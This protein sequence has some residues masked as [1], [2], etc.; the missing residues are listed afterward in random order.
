MIRNEGETTGTDKTAETTDKAADTSAPAT[1]EAGEAEAK[2]APAKRAKDSNKLPAGAVK[3]DMIY[4]DPEKILIPSDPEHYLFDERKDYPVN[5]RQV[6]FSKEFGCK[7]AVIG[8]LTDGKKGKEVLVVDGRQRIGALRQAN[9]EMLAEGTP[10]DM[11]WLMPVTLVDGTELELHT[12]AQAANSFHK[13]DSPS[14]EARKVVAYIKRASGGTWSPEGKALPAK[15]FMDKAALAFNTSLSSVKNRINF[16]KL[17]GD[18]QKAVDKNAIPMTDA[19][20]LTKLEAEE[21]KKALEGLL[22]K[23]GTAKVGADGKVT[24]DEDKAKTR[25]K[26]AKGKPGPALI[27]KIVADAT[28]KAEVQAALSWAIGDITHEEVAKEI[29]GIKAFLP[30]PKQA[31]KPKA[32]KKTAAKG[33]GK[34]K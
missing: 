3:G 1:T 23:N 6:E 17:H 13:G 22:K 30:K 15:E 5:P 29:P 16:T 8:T 25:T 27:R 34:K 2:K 12:T 20:E 31:K 18:V 32:E 28:I 7:L 26:K 14:V 33:K 9:K 19:L 24:I 4:I 11:I 10:P 21:Q